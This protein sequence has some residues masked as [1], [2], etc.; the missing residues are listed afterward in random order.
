M[1]PL[2]LL[3]RSYLY[4]ERQNF[5]YSVVN[6]L[7]GPLENEGNDLVTVRIPAA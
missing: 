4:N 7:T 5:N 2:K 1:A 6:K 3:I